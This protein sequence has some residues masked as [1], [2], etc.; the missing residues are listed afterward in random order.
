VV[1]ITTGG[2]SW[3]R[4]LMPNGGDTTRCPR[5]IGAAITL[6]MAVV[7]ACGGSS[8][9]R[10]QLGINDKTGPELCTIDKNP[11]S[12]KPVQVHGLNGTGLLAGIAAVAAGDAHLLAAARR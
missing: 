12:T 6:G 10:G 4:L 1:E 11:C 7:A 5:A 9:N 2:Q 3:R 8:G